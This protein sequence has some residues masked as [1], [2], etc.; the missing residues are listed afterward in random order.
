MRKESNIVYLHDNCEAQSSLQHFYLFDTRRGEVVHSRVDFNSLLGLFTTSNVKLS[1]E[2]LENVDS[3]LT[4]AIDDYYDNNRVISS[5]HQM[6]TVCGLKCSVS[7]AYARLCSL[8][9]ENP[10]NFSYYI[11][12]HLD[13]DGQINV[14]DNLVPNSIET[15]LQVTSDIFDNMITRYVAKKSNAN[16][17]SKS[18]LVAFNS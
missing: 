18:S 1:D 15:K 8:N 10:S 17:A 16:K 9:T 11:A 5:L 4:T 6:L 2:C 13:E 7:A 12:I 3:I 14:I